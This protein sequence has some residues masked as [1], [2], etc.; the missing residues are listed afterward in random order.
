MELSK[1]QFRTRRC[2]NCYRAYERVKRRKIRANKSNQTRI[3]PDCDVR[4]KSPG[5]CGERCSDC[6]RVV[7]TNRKGEWRDRNREKDRARLRKWELKNKNQ[8]S[9]QVIKSHRKRARFLK[10]L[11]VEEMG[12][13]C[14]KC[15]YSKSLAALSFHHIDPSDKKKNVSQMLRSATIE[16]LRLEVGKCVLLCL[17]CHA[18]I[19]HDEIAES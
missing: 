10:N 4:H 19:H 13:K 14:V 7:E 17:N 16:D 15:N 5:Y 1:E 6:F 3:C 11:L 18:E 9:D 8:K 12:G 2:P